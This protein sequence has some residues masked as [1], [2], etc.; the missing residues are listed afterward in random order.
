MN[1]SSFQSISYLISIIAGL[2]VGSFLNVLILRFDEL[3]TVVKSRS[4]C[5][6]CKKEIKWYDLVPL[7]SYVLLNAKCRYCKKPISIQYPIVE[8]LTAVTF[9]L[10]YWK[11]GFSW[12]S[13]L[14]A[15]SL[16]LLIAVAAYDAINYEIPDALSYGALVAGAGFILVSLFDQGSLTWSN[17][18]PF[19]YA[20]LI[21]G[22]FL[23]MLVV[24]SREKWMGKG[25][26]GLGAAMGLL[27][28]LPSVF[29]GIFI[30]FISGSI[31]GLILLALKKKTMKDA[32]PFGPFLVF[33]TLLA[34]FWGEKIINWY[35]GIF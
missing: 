14:A 5:P 23:A 27:L 17:L 31:I 29:F 34:F 7:L 3:K 28:G 20:I 16:S 9:A 11:L 21:A 22:G 33:G 25:D 2:T 10:I 19:A 35:L 6:H 18:L 13:L 24:I 12:E 32:V 8:G 1:L 26:I 30:A 4:R 15:I